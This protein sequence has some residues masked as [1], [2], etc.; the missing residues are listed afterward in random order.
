MTTELDPPKDMPKDVAAIWGEVVDAHRDAG[1]DSIARK[2]G[3]GLEAYCAITADLRAATAKVSEHGVL[4][5][6]ARGAPVENPA[7]AIKNNAARELARIGDRYQAK[8]P[9]GRTRR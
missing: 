9:R 3:P 5:Q 2:I 8:T 4:V 1:D 6:D 7:I